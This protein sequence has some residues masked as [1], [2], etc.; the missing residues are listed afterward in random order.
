[1]IKGAHDFMAAADR[2]SVLFVG[3]DQWDQA[4]CHSKLESDFTYKWYL[5][6]LI[7][8]FPAQEWVMGP[9]SSLY[10]GSPRC[11]SDEIWSKQKKRAGKLIG[12]LRPLHPPLGI[13]GKLI[14]NPSAKPAR[15][16][17]RLRGGH[18]ISLWKKENLGISG[19]VSA[20]H[21]VTQPLRH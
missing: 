10:V 3:L 15:R 4:T 17:V 21:R 9:I 12:G 7:W 20:L 1:M 5:L 14:K 18:Q 13:Q 11:F 2:A 19:L 6:E 16:S 8:R